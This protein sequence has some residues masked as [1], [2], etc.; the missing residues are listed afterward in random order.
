MSSSRLLAA[1]SLVT[2]LTCA[3]SAATCLLRSCAGGRREP[4]PADLHS[5]ILPTPPVLLV[6]GLG[7]NSSCFSKM[8]RHLNRAGYT[9]YG[10]NYSCF[11][12]DVAA[13][14]RHLAREA[15]W[16]RDETGSERAHVVAHSLGG[17]V[18]RW[19][20]ANTWMRDWVEVAV[21]MGSPHR[22]TPAALL[23]P[24]ALPGFGKIISQLRPGR[25][26]PGDLTGEVRWVAIAPEHDWIVPPEYARLPESQNVRNVVLPWG[27]HMTLPNNDSCLE[28]ILEEFAAAA[29]RRPCELAA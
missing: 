2:E 11:E 17:V 20:V 10:A 26:D 22:G 8:E 28:I 18:L 27:G 23:A 29:A 7:A 24:S 6:H 12:A 21:T 25:H 14:G 1:A 13:C 15:A 4:D 5:G 3:V 19:A 9:V 16:L